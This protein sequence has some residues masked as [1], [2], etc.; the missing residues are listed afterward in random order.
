MRPD[1]VKPLS[2]LIAE[3]EHDLILDPPVEER[4]KARS[5]S[6]CLLLPDP[7]PCTANTP[8]WYREAPDEYLTRE[9]RDV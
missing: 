6:V 2:S 9:W 5:A 8:R 3:L 1:T 7:G 4:E